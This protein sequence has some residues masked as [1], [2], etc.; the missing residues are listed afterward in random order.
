VI[1]F[2]PSSYPGHPNYFASANAYFFPNSS[3]FVGLVGGVLFGGS[4]V[5]LSNDSPCNH[6]SNLRVYFDEKMESL[7]SSPNLNHSS[8][9]GTIFLPTDATT[10][11]HRK[12]CQ[13]LRQ[14]QHRHSSPV[15]LPIA[16]VRQILL[17][18][19]KLQRLHSPW[20]SLEQVV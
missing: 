18:A 6:S 13:R 12:K 1:A 2:G 16:V 10:N 7:D 11:H 5:A 4:I 9:S 8:A 20:P 3:S 17:A 15:S 19:K 14:V